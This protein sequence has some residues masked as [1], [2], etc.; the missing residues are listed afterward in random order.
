MLL[1]NRGFEVVSP[2]N[3]SL[4]DQIKLFQEA[5][6]LVGVKGA[7]FTNVLFCNPGTHMLLLSP[8]YFIDPFFWDLCSQFGVHYS[9]I[10]CK[11]D[12]SSDASRNDIEV[13]LVQVTKAL[14]Q[15]GV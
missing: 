4:G 13:D 15:I 1:R 6:V 12:H 2:E 3:L 8:D 14:D 9:E 10:L 11:I 5:E 7:A